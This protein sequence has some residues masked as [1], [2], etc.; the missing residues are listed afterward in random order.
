MEPLELLGLIIG[1]AIISLTVFYHLI[2]AAIKNAIKESREES[3][4]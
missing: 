4:K 2:K 3:E 1:S